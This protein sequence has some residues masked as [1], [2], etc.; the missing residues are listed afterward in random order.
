MK[1][2]KVEKMEIIKDE[3]GY[4][5]YSPVSDKGE[6]WY[7]F[8]KTFDK[9]TQKVLYDPN[10]Q[11]VISIET[12]ASMIAPTEVGWVVKEIEVQPYSSRINLYLLEDKL[13]NLSQYEYIE[14][15]KVLFNK[16]KKIEDIKKR[17]QELKEGKLNRG[18]QINKGETPEMFQPLREKDLSS[19][20]MYKE[21]LPMEWKYYDVKSEPIA[22]TLD[23]NIYAYII[24]SY[25]KV[26]DALQMSEVSF[27]D[28]VKKMSDEELRMLNIDNSYVDEY[29]SKGGIY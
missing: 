12:D 15:G 28:K 5:Y 17:V 20:E 1:T 26:M 2:F 13:V 11:R 22:G 19:L 25:P 29:F 3:E 27:L 18:I 21:K 7:E 14:N 8:L 23:T 4:G 6:N 24:T 9:D 16:D 10:T